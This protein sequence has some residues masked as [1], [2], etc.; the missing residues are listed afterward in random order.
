[1]EEVPLPTE[2]DLHAEAVALAP[3]PEWQVRSWED[4]GETLEGRRSGLKVLRSAARAEAYRLSQRAG[5]SPKTAAAA[6]S[7]ASANA[8]AVAAAL[9]TMAD[10]D[11]QFLL[12]FLRH[13]KFDAPAAC[14]RLRKFAGFMVDNPWTLAPDR[15]V[16]EE[17]FG[18][19]A[20]PLSLVPTPAL[21][22]ERVLVLT[23]Q[24]VRGLTPADMGNVFNRAIFWGLVCL[25]REPVAQLGGVCFVDDMAMMVLSQLRLVGSEPNRYM[26]FMLQ[27]ILPLRL[28][29]MHVFRQPAIFSLVWAIARTF[30]ARKVQDRLQM[31]GQD[32]AKLIETVGAHAVPVSAGGTAVVT[33][34]RTLTAMV[35]GIAATPWLNAAR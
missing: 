9:V 3:P 30:I 32:T 11:A 26:W 16:L 34:D 35:K 27:Q 33:S 17:T 22:G 2:A 7:P 20:G 15:A 23:I 25:L 31:Y 13:A 18:G 4:L 29:G 10:H 24:R 6:P 12:S 14:A 21:G 28:R 19:R 1:M 5:R 8:A